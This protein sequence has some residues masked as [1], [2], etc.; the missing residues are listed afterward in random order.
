MKNQIVI[1]AI[2]LF[3][4]QGYTQ[5]LC[6]NGMAGIY[7]CKD[8]DLMSH[9]NLSTFGA[10]AGNDS[11]G[12]TDSLN[13]KEY[14]IMGVNNGTV[15]VDVSNP[16]SPVY[17]GKLPTATVN[18]S[19]RDV[20]VYKNHAFMVSEALD[21]GMQVFDL[22][23]LRNVVSPPQ[24]FTADKHFTEF[25]SAHNIVINE[26]TGYAYVVGTSKGGYYRGGPIFVNIQNPINP[27]IEG[28]FL[29]GG[30]EPYS[31]DAQV[32]TYNGPDADYIG[33]EI[34]IGS[35]EI[36]VVIADVTDKSYP[37]TI[38]AISYPD[39]KYTHQGW[40]TEDMKYFLLG[41]ELDEQNVGFNTRTIV[42]DFQDLDY[43]KEHMVYT[44]PTAAIDHN[45]YVKGNNFY[46]ANYSSG[47]RV[48]DISN[49]GAKTMTEV[50]YFDTYPSGNNANFGGVWNVYP[51]FPSGNILISDLNTG[52]YLV[53]KSNPLG[54]E[55]N[56]SSKKKIVMFPNPV[57]SK[58]TIDGGDGF[59]FEKIEIYNI[60][61]GKVGEFHEFDTSSEISFNVNYPRGIYL[62]TINYSLTKKL[63]IQ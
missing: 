21:H 30:A 4:I 12:W 48:V 34:L 22:T 61:G 28:G 63:V 26:D 24:T 47:I 41:D 33:R 11:W 7:P 54:V 44:G 9:I 51:Y 5:T 58:L 62:I 31:H 3:L 15:F 1:L 46:L 42:F 27:V 13:G 38:S 52:L 43:P 2:T 55:E 45:G 59:R 39:V 53:R 25:G 29:S 50:G 19:W 49:I 20:K 17:L 23:R 60:F 6:N 10:L 57:K 36:E 40:F 16:V 14:A 8:Y 56:S 32:I 35:N 37:F 18:S